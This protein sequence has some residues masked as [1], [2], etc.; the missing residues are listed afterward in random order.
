MRTNASRSR[1]FQLI[2]LTVA[3]MSLA[4][5]VSARVPDVVPA[6]EFVIDSP[7]PTPKD[8]KSPVPTDDIT[9][10]PTPTPESTR[11]S[12]T[13]T[14]E[15][16][17]LSPE[18][19]AVASES[20]T[21][22]PSPTPT[23]T[24]TETPTESPD[25]SASPTASVVV[26]PTSDASAHAPQVEV[27]GAP[28]DFRPHFT[29]ELKALIGQPLDAAHVIV[30]AA[31]LAAGSVIVMEM[32][33]DPI[34][35]GSAVV[36]LDGGVSLL[37]ELPDS[38]PAGVHAIYI[39]GTSDPSGPLPAA[40]ERVVT[41]AV[42]ENGIVI[43]AMQDLREVPALGSEPQA[44]PAP[45]AGRGE[46]TIIRQQS[47]TLVYIDER[48][49]TSATAASLRAAADVL[50]TPATYSG[51]AVTILIVAL[52]GIALEFPFNLIQER[53]KR[54]Y[55]EL[56]S[57]IRRSSSDP[58]APRIF[59]IRADV[60]L[61]LAAGQVLAQLNAPIEAIPPLGQVAQSAAFGAIA[62]FAI[63]T[64]YAIPQMLLHRKRDRDTGDFRAEWPS[65]LVASIA[66]IAAHLSGVVPGFLIGLFTVR[67]F[68]TVLPEALTAR[69]AW[70]AT[71]LLVAFATVAWFLMDAVDSAV[72]DA[73]LPIRV[74]VDGVL[75]VVVVAGSQG[76]LLN[77]V[78][79]G[80]GGAMALRRSSLLGWFT[81][82]AASGG[83]SFALLATEEIDLAL[84]APPSSAQ[85][86]LALLAFA[87]ASL[88]AIVLLNRWAARRQAARGLPKV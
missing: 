31:G 14:S 54:A 66:L 16:P 46:T 20:P 51:G 43:G 9:P 35:L 23:P 37:V 17:V 33:S 85:E 15:A 47:G 44:P 83:L 7:T 55:G 57:R 4:A 19:T 25:P 3:C 76:A 12:A 26:D 59:G 50:T 34:D 11:P 48:V 39:R 53:A 87:T 65:L 10:T 5:T 78:D 40:V 84:F 30:D 8:E 82:I 81:A 63:S 79:P 41:I 56:L 22:K 38:V 24:A 86:Y 68:R 18:P 60:F 58:A 64:W 36:G 42:D 88:A 72:P 27:F 74:V 70:T 67:K 49:S 45:V 62:V 77:L 28:G 80:D 71:M 52:L 69:G 21:A 13:P 29:V 32:R 1:A 2:L 61:F 6:N 75:G 73:T